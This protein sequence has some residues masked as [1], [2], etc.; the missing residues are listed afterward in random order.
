MQNQ[1]AL[2]SECHLL[3]ILSLNASQIIYKKFFLCTKTHA[4]DFFLKY[5]VKKTRY[6]YN[7]TIMKSQVSQTSH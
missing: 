6:D 4:E 1:N 7:L 5:N 2:Y 3:H